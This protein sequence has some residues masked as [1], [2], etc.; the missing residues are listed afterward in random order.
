[1]APGNLASRLFPG[2]RPLLVKTS[3]KSLGLLAIGFV[4]PAI[5]ARISRSAAGAGYHALTRSDPPRNPAHPRVEW[6]DAILWTVFSGAIG[7]LTRLAVRRM[8][9]ETIIPTEGDDF[10]AK[11]DEELRG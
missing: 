8:L 7:G 11:L 2:N 5:A 6:K 1:M 3:P 4:L 9:S 10:E